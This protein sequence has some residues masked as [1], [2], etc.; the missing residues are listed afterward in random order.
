MHTI[1]RAAEREARELIARLGVKPPIIV[2]NLID[3]LCLEYAE[4][5][6]GA[7]VEGYYYR[8]FDGQGHVVVNDHPSKSEGRRRFTALHE[9]Y[10]HIISK[11]ANGNVY[12]MDS[13]ATRSN[14]VEIACNTFAADYL[15][16]EEDVIGMFEELRVYARAHISKRWQHVSALRQLRQEYV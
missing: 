15:M 7:D 13:A 1:V 9:C 6:Y 14:V 16:P 5:G 8:T 12:Y 4:K 11:H 3:Y 2:R 10:H